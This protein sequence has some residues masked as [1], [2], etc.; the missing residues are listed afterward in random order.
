MADGPKC[1]CGQFAVVKQSNKDN[2]NKGRSFFAC[3]NPQE[4][5]CRFFC[6]SEDDPYEALQRQ[7]AR[8]ARGSSGNYYSQQRGGAVGGFSQRGGLARAQNSR[9][10]FNGGNNAARPGGNFVGQQQ[11]P[12]EKP[13]SVVPPATNDYSNQ[14]SSMEVDVPNNQQHSGGSV[15]D[16][17]AAARGGHASGNADALC[18]RV[19]RCE[20]SLTELMELMNKNMSGILTDVKTQLEHQQGHMEAITKWI[21]SH[22]EEQDAKKKTQAKK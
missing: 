18:Q 3:P 8:N 19:D 17:P 7:M 20:R 14:S 15:S 6:W 12:W 16:V 4:T 5:S 21:Q 11:S 22:V 10:G 9:G 1:A 13:Y 2:E